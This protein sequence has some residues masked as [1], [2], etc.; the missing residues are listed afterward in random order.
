MRRDTEIRLVVYIGWPEWLTFLTVQY[1]SAIIVNQRYLCQQY[2]RG[3]I[4][5]ARTTEVNKEEYTTNL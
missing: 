3:H 1:W 5:L 4:L 2:S